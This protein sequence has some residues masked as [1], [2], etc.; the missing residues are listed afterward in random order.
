MFCSRFQDCL[1]TNGD[2]D[3][4]IEDAIT[5]YWVREIRN[6]I[7]GEH[8]AHIMKAL[9]IAAQ[10]GSYLYCLFRPGSHYDGC[11][12]YAR[13]EV[14]ISKVGE[15]TYRPLEEAQLLQ[16]FKEFGFHGALLEDIVRLCEIQAPVEEITTLRRLQRLVLAGGE[17]SGHT[18]NQVSKKISRLAFAEKPEGINAS[19][20]DKI[21]N[22]LSSDGPI[23]DDLYLHHSEFWTENRTKSIL[24]CFGQMVPSFFVGNQKILA[25][26]VSGKNA[27]KAAPYSSA[28]PPCLQVKSLPLAS[29]AIHWESMMQGGWMMANTNP[30]PGGR[31]FRSQEGVNVWKSLGVFLNKTVTRYSERIQKELV[32]EGRKIAG[33]KR[34]PDDDDGRDAKRREFS[35]QGLQVENW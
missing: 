22:L 3:D 15:E 20:L 5:H 29:A 30:V 1:T 9:D 34:G 4:E 25:T 24:S 11:I 21:F 32:D 26:S 18:R 6:T 8:L 35:F 2:D 33:K 19:S 14:K 12:I 23:P 27:Q 31:V 17:P 16:E 10:T 28:K 7:F 13:P